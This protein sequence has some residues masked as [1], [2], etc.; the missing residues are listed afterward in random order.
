[1]NDQDLQNR[2]ARAGEHYR[3]HPGEL[4]DLDAVLDAARHE[5]HRH[6]VWLTTAAAAIG[7]VGVV[8][9]V[10]L[11]G[12]DRNRPSTAQSSVQTPPTSI[13]HSGKTLTYVGEEVWS[14]PVLDESNA[15]K[16]IVYADVNGGT[17]KWGEYC[18]TGTT[19]V[20]RVVSQNATA[21]RIAVAK[22]AVG[23]T[24]NGPIACADT[25]R[26]PVPLT[27]T[28]AQPLGDR[29]LIDA[30]HDVPRK[31]LDPK[32]VLKPTDVPTGYTGGQATW[33]SD[34]TG[35][36][37][38]YYHGSRS[39]LTFTFG[40]ASLSKPLQ[41]IVRHAT[42]RGHDATVSYSGGF[43][44]DIQIAWNEDSTHAVALYQ[45]GHD[46]KGELAALSADQLIQI[47]NSIR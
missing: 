37:E 28:L 13:Q 35:A 36:A 4:P 24:N 39:D 2:L 11:T 31:V 47:A 38:R 8:V 41:H 22:Y 43:S 25:F 7:V 23:M 10:Q 34:V 40:S 27:V 45:M 19:A 5:Q 21:V 29:P 16:V 26:L 44:E 17:S 12:H 42:V 9:A 18:G 32:T 46:Q 15:N 14:K 1:M 30:T 33:S 20:A 6:R 3:R